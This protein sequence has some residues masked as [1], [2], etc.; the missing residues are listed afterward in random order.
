MKNILTNKLAYSLV[1]MLVSISAFA[2]EPNPS[3]PP[4]DVPSAPIDSHVWVL[5]FFAVLIA[6]KTLR[7]IKN[8]SKF[9]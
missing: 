7:H 2:D 3:E 8:E 5:M 4:E 9:R 6:C 1:L